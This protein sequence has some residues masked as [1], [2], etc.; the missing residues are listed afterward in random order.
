MKQNADNNSGKYAKWEDA[1]ATVG[2]FLGGLL[3]A[4]AL[5]MA[6]GSGT[7]SLAALAL[8]VVACY[9]TANKKPLSPQQRLERLE[10][11]K[12]SG[13]LTEEEYAAKRQEILND[14]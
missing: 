12:A 9:R 13:R 10:E 7:A 4:V 14:L 1:L 3:L 8:A 5:D 2:I 11:L 6:L